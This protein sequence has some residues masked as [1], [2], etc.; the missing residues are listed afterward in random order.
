MKKLNKNVMT[1]II[2]FVIII[3]GLSSGGFSKFLVHGIEEAKVYATEK[4]MFQGFSLFTKKVESAFSEG[5]TY[6]KDFLDINSAV[7]KNLGTVLID[8]GDN[9]VV[10]SKSD[11]LVYLRDEIDKTTLKNRAKNISEL[12]KISKNNG[13]DFLYV[14]APTKGYNIELPDN[15]LDFN[16]SN[17][18][19]FLNEL[20]GAGVPYFS[21]IAEMENEGIS[22]EELF[23]ATDHHWKPEYA[24][25]AANKVSTELD[26]R[27]GYDFDKD[28]FDIKNYNVKVYKDWFLGSQGKK[29][30]QHF[31]GCGNDDISLITPKFKTSFIDTHVGKDYSSQGSFEEVLIHKSHI[32][33][34]DLYNKNPYA[35]YLGGDYREEI[36][37]NTLNKNGKKVL[38]LKDSFACAFTPFFANTNQFTYLL[39]MRDFDEF[40]GERINVEEYIKNIQPDIVMIM[41]T[42]VTSDDTVFDFK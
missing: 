26:K 6:H 23:F 16:K 9:I 3:A 8:K 14:M 34:K 35:T 13:A 42:G 41:Y 33:E 11:Y 1:F 32:E 31:S 12:T 18:D 20:E 30:G 38:I 29:T 15:I 27:Y 10:K 24:L 2:I 40:A 28:K 21:L 37:E 22:E 36:I 7:Q 4:G 39:D 17:C 5:L 25:W 19:Y